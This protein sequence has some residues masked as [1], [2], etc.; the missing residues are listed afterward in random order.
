M[1]LRMF[2][3]LVLVV[4]AAGCEGKALFQ[5]QKT[6][7]APTL[8]AEVEITASGMHRLTRDEYDNTLRDL[9][10][11]TSN[12]GMQRLPE[13]VADPFDNDFRHQQVSGALIETVEALAT[14][15]AARALADPAK[16][17]FLVQCTPS[18]PG[19]TDCLRK[20]IQTFG[21]RALRQTLSEEEVQKYLGLS[22]LAVEANDFWVGV[23]LVIRAMLQDPR[24]LYRPEVGIAVQDRP[25]VFKLTDWEIASRLSYFLWGSMPPD[26][27]LDLA[28]QKALSTPAQVRA[29]AEKL[30]ADPKAQTRMD[31]FHALWFGY[32][33]LPH[34]P[35]LTQAMREESAALVKKIVFEEP[36]DYF[37]IFTA[38]QTYANDLLATHYGLPAPGSQTAA[39]LSYGAS[40]RKGILS[41]GS[42]LS[43]GAKFSDTSPTQRGIWVR[44]RLLCQ[45]VAPPPPS[46]NAD[47]P[48]AATNGGNCKKDRYAAHANVGSC[49]SCHRNLD[50]IGW[51]LESYDKAGRFR[52]H[53]DGDP[54]CLIDGKG[55]VTEQ[56]DFTGPAG[57]ADMLMASGKLE[58]CVATQMF[59]FA[60]GRR[61]TLADA[62][63]VDG[64][65]NQWKAKDRNFQDLVLTVVSDPTFAHRK[66]E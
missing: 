48:P 37:R 35:E 18:G 52:A 40:G 64:W 23:D 27:L 11:D 60:H 34:A 49:A 20:F 63:T 22:A 28:E 26:W 30:L 65:V 66:E 14:E 6:P 1:L 38:D 8:A 45:E 56:G 32:H 33:Q 15:A 51:G 24:F 55:T 36:G 29:A 41:H 53:D 16:R 42:V 4:V 44:T 17:D 25:G 9:L 5:P 62:Q 7:D 54:T 3:G 10:A 2:G 61:E 21:R 19:D 12:A 39:W 57:L 58:Y 46:V 59:R 13:D 50:G 47:E 31:R 43:Q